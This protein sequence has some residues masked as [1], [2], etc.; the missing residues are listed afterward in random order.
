MKSGLEKE[1]K[2]LIRFPLSQEAKEIVLD[3]ADAPAHMVQTYL[4]VKDGFCERVRMVSVEMWGRNMA[5][6]YYHTTKKFISPGVNQE[7]E[8]QITRTEYH[9]LLMKADPSLNEIVKTRYFVTWAGKLFELDLFHEQH[10]GLAILEIELTDMESVFELPPF[11]EVIR[12][13]TAEKEFSN[14]ALAAKKN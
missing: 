9:E 3:K 10:E 8:E 6:H 14:A 2:F 5:P 4:E 7:D 12:E 1:R 11:L 13:V